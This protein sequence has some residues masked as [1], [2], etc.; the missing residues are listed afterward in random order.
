MKIN[1]THRIQSLTARRL[2]IILDQAIKVGYKKSKNK[3]KFDFVLA[4]RSIR[5]N[6]R[7]TVNY[8]NNGKKIITN[9]KK[10]SCCK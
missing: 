6:T 8:L 2:E 7:K 4:W 9:K 3:R 5:D 1:N 10:L